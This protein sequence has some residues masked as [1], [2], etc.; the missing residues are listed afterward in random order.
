MIGLAPDLVFRASGDVAEINRSWASDR[1]AFAAAGQPTLAAL[2]TLVAECRAD[3]PAELPRALACLVG[4]FGYET[5]GLV[6][7][8]DCGGDADRGAGQVFWA[9]IPPSTGMMAPLRYDA[10][11]RTSERVICATSSGSP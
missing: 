8:G 10:A 3:V 1:D 5:I 6:E 4:Y 7:R 11:G 9:I 2:R